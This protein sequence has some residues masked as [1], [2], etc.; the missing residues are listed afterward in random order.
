[1]KIVVDVCLP[2]SW[3]ALLNSAGFSVVHWSTI[4]NRAA[5]DLEIMEWAKDNN[6]VVFTH[7]LDFGDILA[8]SGLHGPSVILIR[9]PDVTSGHMGEM[10][11]N[12]IAKYQAALE[13]GALIVID[14]AKMRIRMLPL[15][16]RA[17]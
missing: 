4:G 10:V 3:V 8:M 7:D 17:D 12:A 15:K 9:T 6:A 1:M 2:P 5:P 11:L 16:K 14:E 13:R